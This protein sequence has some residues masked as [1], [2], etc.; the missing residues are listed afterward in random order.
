MA[1]VKPFGGWRYNPE[2][3]PD[4][5]QVLAPP[6]DVIDERKKEEFLRRSPWNMVR[7]IDKEADPLSVFSL[8]QE[9][10][11]KKIL[12]PEEKPCFYLLKHRF[13]YQ[14]RA[15]ERLGVIVALKLEDFSTG[16]VR[17]HEQ[18]FT[19]YRDNRLR[20]IELCKTNFSPVFLLYDDP[21]FSLE[22][23]ADQTTWVTTASFEG[24]TLS[25]GQISRLEQIS[26]IESFFQ[27]K[28][29]FI[30]DGHHR[31]QAALIHAQNH[32]EEKN[33]YVLAYLA[34]LQSPALL[35][36]PTHR[37]VPV[38]FSFDQSGLQVYFQ[39]QAQPD[40]PCLLAS[41]SGDGPASFGL[42]DG[43]SFYLLS[44]K[45]FQPILPYLP[46]GKSL[47]WKTLDGVILHYFLLPRFL[48]LPPETD[49]KV[50][51]YDPVPEVVMNKR[52][53]EGRGVVFFLRPV[54]KEQFTAVALAGEFMPQKS[55]Y[56]FPK[57]PTGL[58]VHYFGEE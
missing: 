56:F 57:V 4:L 33:Q 24:E 15:F 37:Y 55:T 14:G 9:W 1:K 12:L 26:Q 8:W 58:V 51:F 34:N 35:L 3:V 19:H 18:I 31:Y 21:G 41:L 17:P 29:L 13:F 53:R 42:W 44:L 43:K 5:G 20:L 32:P 48:G 2:A 30:A 52:L 27:A 6:W 45:D 7:L 40:L 54:R 36:A 38:N 47:C 22:E 11:K 10:R 28:T 46:E 16:L 23:L 25:L 49:R 50:L 39:V